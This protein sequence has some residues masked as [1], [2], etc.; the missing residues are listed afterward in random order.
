MSIST[1]HKIFTKIYIILLK[2]NKT[3][4]TLFNVKTGVKNKK[5]S[6]VFFNEIY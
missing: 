3:H 6:K 5:M 4:I 2:N 1:Y